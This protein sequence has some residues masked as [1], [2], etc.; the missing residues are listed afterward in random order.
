MANLKALRE[1][2]KNIT[3]YSPELQQFNDQIDELLN[4]AYYS[5]WTYKRWSFATQLTTLRFYTDITST[6]D[7]E[8]AGAATSV[9]LAIA[10]GTRLC[11]FSADIDRLLL[12]VWEGQP[13]QLGNMEY[14]I[15]KVLTKNTILLVNDYVG[16]TLTDST[17]WKIKKRWYSLPQNCLELLYL[18]HRDY[19]YVS[20]TGTQN[21]YGKSTAILPRREENLDLRVD[22]AKDY[23]EA[24]ITSPT[25]TIPPAEQTKLSQPAASGTFLSGRSYEFCWAFVKDGKIGALSEPATYTVAEDNTSISIGFIGWDGLDIVADSYQAEDTRAS[26]WEGY[27]KVIFWNKNFNQVT[28]QRQGLPCWLAVTNGGA[29]RNVSS[30]LAPVLVQDTAA[31]YNITNTNQLDNGSE[32]YI[33]IDGQHQQIRPYPRVIG[34][35]FEVT[36][37]KDAGGNVIVGHDYVREGVMRYVKKPHDLLLNT[38]VPQMP[39]EF[40]QLIVY[41]ALED[42]YLKLGQ[43]GMASTYEKKYE[44]ELKS[45]QKRYVDKID[46][47]VVRGQF[48][49]PNPYGGVYDGTTLRHL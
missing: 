25:A 19:P 35:D 2:I 32:S 43:Q 30:Y 13:I 15:S 1:K 3:D 27:R 10:Q 29:T 9:N 31:S 17:D 45:L 37:Q 47:Q 18:G 23:A 11:T 8:N 16:D 4:D 22:Y 20:T 7:L 42:I 36:Q 39:Y 40:H 49:N 24:Y 6:T 12:D 41:K 14:T 5:L 44:K 21:P 33:E 38:D 48:G 34:W 28:G 46:F 26:Q